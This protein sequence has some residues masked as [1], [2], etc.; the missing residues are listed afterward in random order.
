[1]L[2]LR[3]LF[4]I[5][6]FVIDIFCLSNTFESFKKC[7]PNLACI[8]REAN[9]PKKNRTMWGPNLKNLEFENQFYDS[10]YATQGM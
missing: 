9:C 8:G 1:M 4:I 7:F 3:N 2:K 5:L 10:V 6:E